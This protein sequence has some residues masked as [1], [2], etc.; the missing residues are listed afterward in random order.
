MTACRSGAPLPTLK[1]I[2]GMNRTSIEKSLVA[3][4]A[5][6]GAASYAATPDYHYKTSTSTYGTAAA[7]ATTPPGGL[8]DRSGYVVAAVV[9]SSGGLEVKAWQDTTH[10]LNEVGYVDAES[11]SRAAGDLRTR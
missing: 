9:D 3:A 8:D 10:A 11:E 5:L 2:A 6:A 7:I 1:E 4:L